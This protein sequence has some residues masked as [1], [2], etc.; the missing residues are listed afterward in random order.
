MPNSHGHIFSLEFRPF[1]NVTSASVYMYQ[2]S[3]I[4]PEDYMLCEDIKACLSVF[5]SSEDGLEMRN[6]NTMQLQCL[7]QDPDEAS[8]VCKAW[9]ECLEVSNHKDRIL[10]LLEAF[11]TVEQAPMSLT[12][13]QE[14]VGDECDECFHPPSQD[15]ESWDCD[16]YDTMMVNCHE[17]NAT[18]GYDEAVCLKAQICAAPCL[19]TSW[20][21]AECQTVA[22]EKMLQMLIQPNLLLFQQL[23]QNKRLGYDDSGQGLCANFVQT[24]DQ[25]VTDL[26]SSPTRRRR[27]RKKEQGGGV[28]GR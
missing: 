16:C 8:R 28:R 26:S 14:T 17:I 12:D 18:V 9:V 4:A 21:T 11:G 5:A 3:A 23:Q 15:P 6:N 10:V 20:F 25:S 2:L 22:I 7:R 1:P 19:C 13:T 24:S 27:R